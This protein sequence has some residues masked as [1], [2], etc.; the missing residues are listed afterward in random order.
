MHHCIVSAGYTCANL[1]K[2]ARVGGPGSLAGKPSGR[3]R[4]YT[5]DISKEGLMGRR[6]GLVVIVAAAVV[7]ATVSAASARPAAKA[8]ATASCSAGVT[9]GMLAPITGP[10][11]SIGSDQLH[12]AQFFFTQW[13]KTHK[14]KITLAQ[15]DDQLDP[16]KAATGAQS[17]ASNSSVMGVIGPAGSD[18]V[19]AVAPILKKA[20]L[21]FASG[22]ATRVSLTR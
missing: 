15:F 11:G 4:V 14:P 19:I 9:I 13:N 12:W 5:G 20:G 21:A 22:S 10:A 1:L 6:H 3:L 17:F 16:A 8:T 2:A 7:L 18:Q